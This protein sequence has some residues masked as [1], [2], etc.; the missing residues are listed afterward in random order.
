MSPVWLS[1]V[2]IGEDG[3]DGLSD[4]ARAIVATA[5]ILIGGDRHLAM[6]PDDGRLRVRWPTPIAAAADRI[7][8]FRPRQVCVLASGD[9]MCFGIGTVLARNFPIAEMRIFPAPSAFSLACS[10]LG[11]PAH[12]TEQLTLHG[13]PLALLEPFLHPGN[14]LLLLSENAETPAKVADLL[15]R[16]GFGD[17]AMVVLERMGG[18]HEQ[19]RTGIAMTWNHPPG[20][21]LNTIAVDLVAGETAIVRPRIPGLPDSAY[22][23]DGQLTRRE[24]RAISLASLAPTP[25]GLL[26]DVGAGSGSI[27]I[28]WMRSS[29]SCRAIAI[30]ARPDRRV[31]IADNALT[32]GVP[33][34]EIVSGMAPDALRGLEAPDA[35]F[36][37]GGLTC[38][39]M[40]ETCLAALRPGGR[41]VAN[42]VTLEGEG[43]LSRCYARHGGSLARVA[44]SH[45]G[46]VGSFH[47]WRPAM[48]VVHWCLAKARGSG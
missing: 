47:G 37:G 21:D 8:E 2:G 6:F 26:W 3:P 19:R 33:G 9:P 1:V 18:P 48:P 23:N 29:R 15:N 32:L 27:A 44:V 24:L 20:A 10:R 45:A 17:S 14:R 28:E 38:A 42:A 35:V 5:E 11:W 25:N 43:I 16:R 46:P 31:M 34:L 30:E 12:T 41:L 4:A 7:R 39:D 13:R 36:I 22:A 40:V